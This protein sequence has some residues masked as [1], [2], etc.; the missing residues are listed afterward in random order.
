MNVIKKA[1][2]WIDRGI[3]VLMAV[4]LGGMTVIIFAQVVFRYIL[5]SPLSWSEELSRYLFVWVSFIGSVVAARRGQHIGVELLVNRFPTQIQKVIR[6]LAHF[7]TAGFFAVI[8]YSIILMWPKLMAQTTSALKLPM[9]YPYLGL[10]IGCALL[11]LSYL[12]E[13]ILTLAKSEEVQD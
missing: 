6:C 3:A 4:C 7:V 5:K 8:L 13:A 12:T 1:W 9:G 11:T 10:A 2:T